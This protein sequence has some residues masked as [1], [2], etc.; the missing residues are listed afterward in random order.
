MARSCA[1]GAWM[2]VRINLK[3]LKNDELRK[4]YAEEADTLL[5]EIRSQT[6]S[7]LD[8]VEGKLR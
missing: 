5:E 6:K 7:I 3:D 2:N 8:I 1:E 4:K